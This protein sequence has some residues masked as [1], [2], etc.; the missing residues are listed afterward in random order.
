[1][2]I[3]EKALQGMELLKREFTI[4]GNGDAKKG[5]HLFMII[6]A[7]LIH[8]RKKHNWK[9]QTNEWAAWAVFDEAQELLEAAKYNQGKRH[10]MYEAVDTMATAVRDYHREWE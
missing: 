3:E 2:K 1:M 9:G 10:E 8:A 5:L 6:N 4:F 7:R